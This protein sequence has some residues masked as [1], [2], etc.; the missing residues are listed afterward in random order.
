MSKVHGWKLQLI[1]DWLCGSGG[2]HQRT[3]K[4]PAQGARFNF[5]SAAA[6]RH[7]GAIIF[8]PSAELAGP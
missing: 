4:K 5:P 6:L 3:V 8:A 7:Y 2:A 1:H